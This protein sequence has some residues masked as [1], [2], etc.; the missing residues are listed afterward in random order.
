MIMLILSKCTGI[1]FK[2]YKN[3]V[4]LLSDA[5]PKTVD[6]LILQ[7]KKNADK[8]CK[9]VTYRDKKECVLEK[10]FEYPN[11]K[12]RQRVY[13]TRYLSINGCEKVKSVTLKDDNISR[14]MFT[15]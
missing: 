15:Y 6:E 12:L 14:D 8:I 7:S 5:I 13:R 4:I 10:S 11:N 2:K 1:R 9:I 3:E